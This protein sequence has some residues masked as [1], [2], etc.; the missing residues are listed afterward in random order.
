MNFLPE[1]LISRLEFIEDVFTK[2]I[3]V[4][5]HPTKNL[6]A[7]IYI[8][9][10]EGFNEHKPGAVIT[11]S[12]NL[13]EAGLGIRG[14]KSNYEFNVLLHDFDDV[15][16]ATAD[17]E[18]LWKES[19]DVL[20]KDIKEVAASDKAFARAKNAPDAATAQREVKAIYELIPRPRSRR[21]LPAAAGPPPR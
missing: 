13:T 4:R 10:P 18:A 16:F 9:R 5:A 8:F 3:H 19:V 20:P 7:K 17:F 6:H 2:R 15:V 14:P 12:S 1:L 11:G 21:T